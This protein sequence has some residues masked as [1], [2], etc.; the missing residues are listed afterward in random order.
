MGANSVAIAIP[1]T[2]NGADSNGTGVKSKTLQAS[3]MDRAAA[4]PRARGPQ[5]ISGRAIA[6]MFTVALSTV[7]DLRK[8]S[9][10]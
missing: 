4:I 2:N 1:S 7:R 9:K 10:P 5:A 8:T 6:P 3:D